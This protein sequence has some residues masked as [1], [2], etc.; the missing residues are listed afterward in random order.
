MSRLFANAGDL[1]ATFTPG[2][3]T[4]TPISIFFWVKK[5]WDTNSDT[6]F[7]VGQAASLDQSI[8]ISNNAT[9]NLVR[10]T[11]RDTA[12]AISDLTF[13][14][15]G[16]GNGIWVP[17]LAVFQ[18]NSRQ[19]SALFPR[20]SSSPN[21]TVKSQTGLTSLVIGRS[22]ASSNGV[23]GAMAEVCMWNR[24]LTAADFEIL[25][26]GVGQGTSPGELHV[27][28]IIAYWPLDTASLDDASGNG[29]TLALNGTA[30]FDADHP[31][32]VTSSVAMQM[33]VHPNAAGADDVIGTVFDQSLSTVIGSFTAQQFDSVLDGSGAAALYVPADAFGGEALTAGISVYAYA[34]SQATGYESGLVLCTMVS[35]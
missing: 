3:D 17:V 25:V 14:V 21:A 23:N 7:N 8:Y 10:A 2:L 6:F 5:T 12:N 22:L 26:T 35:V 19:V 29:H 32:I 9:A 18:A 30:N 1:R 13:A 11:A 15:A 16:E 33:L 24:A 34:F 28:D 27:S 31:V 4:V 20:Q